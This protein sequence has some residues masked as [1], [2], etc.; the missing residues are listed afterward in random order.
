MIERRHDWACSGQVIDSALKVHSVLGPGLLETAYLACLAYELRSRGLQVAEQVPVP[1]VY[2]GV[3]I[4][5]A[6][7]MDLLVEEVVVVEAKA[8]AKL[9]PVHHAQLL[10]Y[11]KLGGRNVGLLINFHERRLRD[12]IVRVVNE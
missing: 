4:D 12:G 6:Y 5:V 10:S 11:L 3:R 7:R 1:V 8:V 9:L 2:E